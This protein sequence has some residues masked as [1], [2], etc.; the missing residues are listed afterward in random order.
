MKH[1]IFILSLFVL[2]TVGSFVMADYVE[3]TS[4]APS[5]NTGYPVKTGPDTSV[6][7]FEKIS[8]GI[9]CGT[10]QCS[11]SSMP[12]NWFSLGLYSDKL[13]AMGASQFGVN[14]REASRDIRVFKRTGG[15]FDQYINTFNFNDPN[16][17]ASYTS[18]PMEALVA[19][20]LGSQI[21]VSGQESSKPAYT[22]QLEP[23]TG[24][25]PTT[26]IGLGDSCNLYP[27]NIISGCPSGY[28]ISQYKNPSFSGTLSSSNNTNNQ[29]LATCTE[30]KPSTSPSTS[31]CYNTKSVS[32][33]NKTGAI[34]FDNG[35][36]GEVHYEFFVIEENK[37]IGN[38][39]TQ[40][41]SN[42][43]DVSTTPNP[44]NSGK[45]AKY[46]LSSNC[47]VSGHYTIVASSSPIIPATCPDRNWRPVIEVI[48]DYGQFK[49][50]QFDQ[51]QNSLF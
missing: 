33:G 22:L 3:P 46:R 45:N 43:W 8:T 15:K 12:G 4:S 11:D 49:S 10:Y 31:D 30:F 48:D 29:V 40:T 13:V 41:S 50:L 9:T 39:I 25:S 42:Y 17:Q 7:T 14:Q 18:K 1:K 2:V 34:M 32:T 28:Y 20:G 36:I 21:I 38:Y 19:A 5:S 37:S 47:P 6:R 51:V 35:Y 23:S 26:N 44:T 27:A 16:T 24:F